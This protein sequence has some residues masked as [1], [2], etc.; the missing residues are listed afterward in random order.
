M[1]VGNKCN[2]LFLI[3]FL[4]CALLLC[5]TGTAAVG[6]G[7][8]AESQT[9]GSSRVTNNREAVGSR[10]LSLDD[11]SFEN[12][13]GS[14]LGGEFVWLN[15]FSLTSAD[16]PL[17]M[18]KVQIL[19]PSG[20][21][22]NVGE[23]VDIYIYTDPDGDADP[24]TGMVLEESIKNAAVQAVDD[25]TW[26]SFDLAKPIDIYSTGD[27]LIAVVNRSAGSGLG[28]RPAALD[29]ST[30]QG[31]SWIGI[32][33]SGVIAD[34]PVFPSDNIWGTIDTLGYP[35]N[36]M[37]RG[38]GTT[39]PVQPIPSLSTMGGILLTLMIGIVAGLVFRKRASPGCR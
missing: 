23:L 12:A 17:S 36:W 7:I 20:N 18:E 27:L 35:G 30:S 34:P 33:T 8:S 25:L 29:Q 13:I 21:G 37:I 28:E 6:A 2:Q 19:F 3:C 16:L 24:A 4:Y 5:I 15:R 14:A 1:K 22:I 31:R 39:L 26:S 10:V 9:G 38:Y 32:N 11:G